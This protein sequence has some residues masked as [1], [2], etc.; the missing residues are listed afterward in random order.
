MIFLDSDII[1]YY[2]IDKFDVKE[3]IRNA[4]RSGEIICTTSVNVYEMLKGFRWKNNLQRENELF[5]LLVFIEVHSLSNDVINIAADI[6]ADLRRNGITIGDSDILIAA[7]VIANNGT[8]VTNNTKHFGN[9]KQL[10]V[11]NWVH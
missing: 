9:I 2:F 11:V 5:R 4:L 10:K 8:L 6:Y 7:I 3:K 1:S